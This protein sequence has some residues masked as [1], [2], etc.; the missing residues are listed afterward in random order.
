MEEV[1]VSDCD[2]FLESDVC[3]FSIRKFAKAEIPSEVLYLLQI[4][5]ISGSEIQIINLL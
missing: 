3:I 4:L 2:K 5:F 1:F